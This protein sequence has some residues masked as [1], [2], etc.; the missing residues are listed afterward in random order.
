[1]LQPLA[2]TLLGQGLTSASALTCIS[3]QGN[4]ATTAT[5]HRRQLCSH[6]ILAY[7]RKGKPP[8]APPPY[9]DATGAG[10]SSRDRSTNTTASSRATSFRLTAV[11]DLSQPS[12]CEATVCGAAADSWGASLL[13]VV[14]AH[15]APPRQ[16]AVLA[17]SYACVD[18]VTVPR[19]GSRCCLA[20]GAKATRS[21]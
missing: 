6:A 21:S 11:F 17:D 8:K 15:P 20:R 18:T 9:W 2:A 19:P 10:I 16:G 13:L 4:K 14:A 12:K 1:M 7:M 3:D 5:L